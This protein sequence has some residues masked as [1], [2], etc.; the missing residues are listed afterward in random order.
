MEIQLI[1]FNQK[2]L[3]QKISQFYTQNYYAFKRAYPNKVYT[4]A[5]LRTNIQNA[6][7]IRNSIIN[8]TDIKET[9]INNWKQQGWREFKFLHWFFAVKVS[10]KPNG[11]IIGAIMDAM[12]E[13]QH[14]NDTMQTKPYNESIIRIKE[15]QLRNIIKE[16][17]KKV[18]NII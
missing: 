3:T 4:P 2:Q 14:H 16:S 6:L 15:S 1:P 10:R 13:S 7:S 5:Q 17:I 18:L 11:I 8:D 9:T 12:H